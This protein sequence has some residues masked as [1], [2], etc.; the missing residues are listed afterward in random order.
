MT[1]DPT[2]PTEPGTVADLIPR[3]FRRLVYVVL[4]AVFGLEAIWD[5]IPDVLEGKLLLSLG[6]LGLGMAGIYA[7]RPAS[8][9][10]PPPPPA[11]TTDPT[12]EG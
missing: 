11:P 1:A 9:L 4:G 8:Q 6:A 2:D 10:P 3:R 12:L 7:R 5:F